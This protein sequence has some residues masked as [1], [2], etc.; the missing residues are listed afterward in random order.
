M[1]TSS[2]PVVRLVIFSIIN[3]IFLLPAKAGIFGPAN[4]EECM[5][6]KMKGQERSMYS[7]ASS[8]CREKFPPEPTR[9]VIDLE[10]EDWT[11]EQNPGNKITVTV[12]KLPK[13]AKLEKADAIFYDECE[14]KQSN[15]A[16]QAS[17]EKSTF[18]N[19]FEFTVPFRTFRCA[20]VTFIG[21]AR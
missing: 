10:I 4:Y 16:F 20:R 19:K 15:P 2:I 13:G 11:W 6:E 7:I 1:K 18:G 3:I 17:A 9:K 8:Y 5:L 14:G 21:L 12:K